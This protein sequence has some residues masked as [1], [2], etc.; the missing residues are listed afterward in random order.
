MPNVKKVAKLCA[1]F[2]SG[3]ETVFVN[4]EN[5]QE[6][7]EIDDSV[8][9]AEYKYTYSDSSNTTL[10]SQQA[11]LLI[12]AVERFKQAGLDLNLP[13]IFI[14]YFEQKGVE[15][16]ERFINATMGADMNGLNG[17]PQVLP[18]QDVQAQAGAQGVSPEQMLQMLAGKTNAEAPTNDDEVS[19]KLALFNQLVSRR[20]SEDTLPKLLSEIRKTKKGE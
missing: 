8:R 7:I 2:K 4:K 17:L 11:D 14:W 10:K 6:T 5:K 16:A 19:K 15:N 9:Q 12:Q 13:E 1:D 20:P 18:N 3:V